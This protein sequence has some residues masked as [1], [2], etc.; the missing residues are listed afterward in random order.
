M[1]YSKL[2]HCIDG[3]TIYMEKIKSWLLPHA[4]HKQHF[5]VDCRSKCKRE[6]NTT[7]KKEYRKIVLWDFGRKLFYK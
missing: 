1:N 5:Q 2:T 6:N 4:A 3:K 7:F